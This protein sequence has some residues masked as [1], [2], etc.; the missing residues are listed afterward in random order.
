MAQLILEKNLFGLDIDGRAAQLTGFALMM[1]GRA[2]DQRLFG[3]GVTLNVMA[4]VDSADLDVERLGQRV[5]LAAYGLKSSD[6]MELKRLFEH[7][8][9]CGSLIQVPKALATKLPALRQL[10]N[11]TSQ[12]L[13]V[14]E[15]LKHVRSLVQQAELLA[16]QYDAVV[17]NPPYMGG[18]GM[19]TV[20]KQ[21]AKDH[22]LDAKSDLFACFIERGY[23]LAK[24][25]GHTA[26]VTMQSWMF[27]S[28]FEQ[29]RERMLR[30]KTIGTM[31]HLGARAF[32]SISGEVV[33]TT[34]FVLKNSLA[35]SYKPAFFRLLDG[36]EAEKR[37]A[38]ASGEKRFDATAQ[39]EFKNIPGSPVAYWLCKHTIDQFSRWPPLSQLATTRLGMTTANNDLFTRQWHEVQRDDFIDNATCAK[40]V[41]CSGSRWVP[42]N[43]GGAF[44][45]WYG[46][47]DAVLNW[48]KDGVAI[49]HYGEEEGRIRSTVPNTDFYFRECLTWSKI[50][51]GKLAMRYRPPGSIF[52]VAGACVFGSSANLALIQGV[53]NSAVCMHFLGAFVAHIELRGWADLLSPYRQ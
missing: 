18:K 48:H 30:E 24:D 40:D 51:S 47:M 38:L 1:K 17:A 21:F 4:L 3:R 37:T 45:K 35:G 20:V 33:Q 16:R 5:K 23:T 34:A 6:L 26:M 50:S 11:V 15:A 10:G 46:N 43:K 25:A 22:F 52:D 44:R 13:F 49:K 32:G 39:D 31:A 8:T 19:N 7:A 2:D 27:L 53:T 36:D 9:T 41:I 12:D 42:Y 29:M 14:S 28:S